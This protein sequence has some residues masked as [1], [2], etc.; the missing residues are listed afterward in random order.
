M[1]LK[2]GEG[3][4]KNLKEARRYFTQAAL[5]RD[6]RALYNLGVMLAK[7]EGGEKDI[8]QALALFEKAEAQGFKPA[9]ELMRKYRAQLQKVDAQSLEIEK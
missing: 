1:G 6:A 9:A 3:L 4:P 5:Q 2:A 7:G 8:P